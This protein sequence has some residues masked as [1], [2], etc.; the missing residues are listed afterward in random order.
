MSEGDRHGNNVWN[1]HVMQMNCNYAT[2]WH[3]GTDYNKCSWAPWAKKFTVELTR[4]LEIRKCKST[5]N[6]CYLIKNPLKRAIFSA[7]QTLNELNTFSTGLSNIYPSLTF[8]S[9]S[10]NIWVYFIWFRFRCLCGF[11]ELP[12]AI[13]Y[14]H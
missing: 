12:T 14:Y 10:G 6:I 5:L 2:V 4:V 1:V 8:S 3:S 11:S 13:K 9:P 7:R